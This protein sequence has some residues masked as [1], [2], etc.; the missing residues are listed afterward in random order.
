MAPRCQEEA[1]GRR[2]AAGEGQDGPG[3]SPVFDRQALSLPTY[4]WRQW[5]GRG[6][7]RR[8]GEGAKLSLA[9]DLEKDLGQSGFLISN[10][11]SFAD[12]IKL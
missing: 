9:L 6:G 11:P 8:G 5:E 2:G 4:S 3:G 1:L 10:T 12:F 7:S